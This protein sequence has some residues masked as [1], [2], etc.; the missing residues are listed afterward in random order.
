MH[1][2][3]GLMHRWFKYLYDYEV[4][5]EDVFITWKDQI[6]DKYPGKR[7]A[8][9]QVNRWLTWLQEAEYEE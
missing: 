7:N 3:I 2:L 4:V 6:S 1:Y 5:D 9:F 8:L